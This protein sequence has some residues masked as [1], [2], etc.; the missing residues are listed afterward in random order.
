MLQFLRVSDSTDKSIFY[1]IVFSLQME[2][3]FVLRFLCNFSLKGYKIHYLPQLFLFK[4]FFSFFSFIYSFAFKHKYNNKSLKMKTWINGE[5]IRSINSYVKSR[6]RMELKVGFAV[7]Q[8]VFNSMEASQRK[9]YLEFPFEL[10]RFIWQQT[11]A[12][13]S[14]FLISIWNQI[15]CRHTR[16]SLLSVIKPFN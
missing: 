8:S 12:L 13:I 1:F 10:A 15:I 2:M 4:H 6:F 11:I 7:T 3:F 9:A 16:S 14:S 5:S